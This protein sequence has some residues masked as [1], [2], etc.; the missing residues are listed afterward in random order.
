MNKKYNYIYKTTNN[1][2]G[3]FYI[4]VHSTNK[5]KDGYIGCGIYRQSDAIHKSKKSRFLGFAHAVK[6]YGYKNFTKEILYFFTN[7]EDA[8][9][10]EERTVTK[11]FIQKR[12]NYNLK[13]GG[14]VAPDP[15]GIKRTEKFKKDK[16]KQIMKYMDKLVELSAKDYV[17]VNLN[18]DEVFKVN[19]LAKFCRNN[20]LKP[21][22]LNAVI[23]GRS[24]KTRNNWW[25]C[26][27]ENWTGKVVLRKRKKSQPIKGKLKHKNGKVVEFNCLREASE[28]TGADL[29]TIRKV[30]IGKLRQTKGWS[31]CL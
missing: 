1:I 10:E 7:K 16:A 13:I 26:K 28:K 15:T 18:T 11:D 9:A 25:A 19:N 29:S 3:K 8:Y 5:I 4:G 31:P 12:N 21:D 6:K 22:I 30:I 14:K 2:N 24:V 20:N 17:V 27:K 23:T